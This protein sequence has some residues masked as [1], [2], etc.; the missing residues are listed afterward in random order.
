MRRRGRPTLLAVLAATLLAT[1]TA[2]AATDSKQE[3]AEHFTR[4]VR[5]IDAGKVEE[6]LTEFL[7]AYELSPNY[8]VLYNIG[9][10]YTDL[11]RFTQ[12]EEALRNYLTQGGQNVPARRRSEVERQL[13]T[14]GDQIGQIEVQVNVEG[15]A[16]RIDQHDVGRAPLAGPVRLDAGRHVVS[17]H[18]EGYPLA[19]QAVNVDGNQSTRVTFSLANESPPSPVADS[20]AAVQAAPIVGDIPLR[21]SPPEVQPLPSTPERPI[22]SAGNVQRGIG[23]AAGAI[24]LVGIGVGTGFA[25]RSITKGNESDQQCYPHFGTAPGACSEQGF[26]LNR[27]AMDATTVSIVGFAVGGAALV[28][29]LTLILTAPSN[30]AQPKSGRSEWQ[31]LAIGAGG[32]SFL[33]RW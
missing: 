15:A 25:V 18:L 2:G 23:I 3:A 16:I 27:Q 8:S 31:T 6:G 13:Q 19:E 17:A 12:A 4:A 20:P 21:Q 7:R 1:A 33:S 29:G 24:G 10:A 30:S 11:K 26:E 28:S 5:L 22:S 9:Q 14:L 32:I